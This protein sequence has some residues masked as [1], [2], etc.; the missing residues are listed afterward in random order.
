MLCTHLADTKSEKA[1]NID[2]LLFIESQ[3][4][5]FLTDLSAL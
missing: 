3:N 1:K 5:P 2:F 4:G